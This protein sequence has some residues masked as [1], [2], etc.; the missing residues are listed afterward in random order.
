MGWEIMNHSP[1]SH[2]FIPS[3]FNF[4]GPMMVHLKQKFQTNDDLKCSVLNRLRSQ[5]KSFYA[6]GIGNLP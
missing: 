1:Y 3:D 5:D 2:G 6:T 4:F